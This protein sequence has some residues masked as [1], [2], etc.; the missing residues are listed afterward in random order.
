MCLLTIIS[1]TP[2]FYFLMRWQI[3]R[4]IVRYDNGA[5]FHQ[6]ATLYQYDIATTNRYP[7]YTIQYFVTA[8]AELPTKDLI[9]DFV[10]ITDVLTIEILYHLSVQAF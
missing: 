6:F 10:L 4:K 5:L 7:V 1:P 2:T 9:N 8:S 3:Y